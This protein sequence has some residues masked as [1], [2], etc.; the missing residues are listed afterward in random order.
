MTAAVALDRACAHCSLPVPAGVA[1]AYCCTGCEVVHAAIGEL[2]LERFYALRETAAPA[3]TT[4]RGYSELDDPAFARRH[5]QAATDGHARAALYLED[6]RCTACAWLVEATPRCLPG[7]VEMRVDIGRA[8][9]DVT[10]DPA[11]TSLA[12][13]ARHL[14]RLGHPVHPYRGLDRE[15]QRRREDR[16][17]LVKLGVAG[18]AVGNLMLLAIALYAGLFHGMSAANTTFF[19]WASM[20]IAVPALAFAASPMFKTA[21]GALR[22]RRLHLDL[23]LSIG[24][25]AGLVWG[26]A[27]VIRGVG[28]IYFD[29][30]AMLVFLLL[31]AR[32][33]V[34]RHQR[35]AS[36][37]AELLLAL[38]PR[39]ARRIDDTGAIEDVPLE[40]IARGDLLEVR[41]NE[42]IPVDGV[43]ERG[44][45]AI[46]AGLLTGE[47]RPT[48]VAPGTTVHAGT[49]N[50]AAPITLRAAAVGEHTRVGALV[51]AIEGM[52]ARKA[53]I[54]RLVDRVAG[55]FVQVVTL[56]ALAV[57]VGWSFVSPALGAEHAMALLIVTCPCALALATP[58]AVTVA[59]GRAARKGILIKGADA[60]ERLATP[61]TLVIDKTGTL[62]AGKLAVVSWHGDLDARVLAASLEAASAHP[63]AVAIAASVESRRPVR[64]V[65]EELGRGMRGTVGER[66][67]VVGAPAWVRQQCP[68]AGSTDVERWID[69]VAR[70]GQT[71][72][73]VAVDGAIVAI[74]GLADPVRPDAR[75]ALTALA[76]RGWTVEILSGDDQR[77]V[78]AVGAELGLPPTRC[79]GETSPEGKLAY[80][81]EAREWAPV[82]MVGDG[83]NDAAAIAA[84]TCGIAVSGAAEI[85]IEAADVYVKTPSIA[86]IA[87]IADGAHETLRTIRRSLRF[88]LAY[89]ITA[90]LLA[91]TGLIHPLIGALLMPLSSLTVLAS[92]LR[93]RAF[94]GSP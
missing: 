52:S 28:E 45:S 54:E 43:I 24:I 42:T 76:Q 64:D 17:L 94:R 85:A 89:N 49:V 79:T 12:A 63:I 36:S 68:R 84:A 86:A 74:A 56:T 3:Q 38:I 65:R 7:V 82:V 16:A 73:A 20:A 90:G 81:R 75:A 80:V 35:R 60:L 27:N 71:P 15:Q 13:I 14:D 6:L 8:R 91:V 2:G 51:A 83:V 33:I 34:L 78:S 92:S 58:L 9:A 25:L 53:P 72:I 46:D 47:S 30:L 26:S 5:V 61:G 66:N 4:A 70:Q 93:S 77:V 11:Q 59:L 57:F 21:L 48:D 62:T 67:V 19:R 18:A 39:R 32:W 69:N 23:P 37:A 29:S 31:V 55:R 41:A 50:L 1:S 44:S 22:A 40:A 88:S 10:W 87:A